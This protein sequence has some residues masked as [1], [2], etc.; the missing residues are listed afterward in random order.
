M[1]SLVGSVTRRAWFWLVIVCVLFP[2]V[3]YA[4]EPVRERISLNADWRFEKGDPKEANGQLEYQK[5][6]DWIK[7]TGNEFILNS[8]ATRQTRPAGNLGAE[9][10]YAQRGFDDRGWRQLNLPHDWGIAKAHSNRKTPAR[11]V[12]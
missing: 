2:V 3:A 6:K 5:I 12:S 7:A 10:S 9:I 8:D 4:A 11:P 1:L